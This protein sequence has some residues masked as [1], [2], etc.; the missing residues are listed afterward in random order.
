MEALHKETLVL[1]QAIPAPV[2]LAEQKS[3][4][5]ARFQF[6]VN[7]EVFQTFGIDKYPLPASGPFT[8]DLEHICEHSLKVTID[9]ILSPTPYSTMSLTL[10]QFQVILGEL[11]AFQAYREYHASQALVAD[12]VS[13]PKA[14]SLVLP[15]LVNNST[16][17]ATPAQESSLSVEDDKPE[18]IYGHLVTKGLD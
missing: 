9:D 10:Q 14:S 6:F 11:A 5:L 3:F 7:T 17:N 2:T 4:Y 8:P 16:G 13:T 18:F 12:D 15:I 1:F